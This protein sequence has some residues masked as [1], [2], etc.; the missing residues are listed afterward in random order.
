M[1]RFPFYSILLLPVLSSCFCF[2]KVTGRSSVRDL[3]T[4][5]SFSLCHHCPGK[6]KSS[7]I[8]PYYGFPETDRSAFIKNEQSISETEPIKESQFVGQF[9]ISANHWVAPGRFFPFRILGLGLDY[10]YNKFNLELTDRTYDQIN[11]RI[12]A[13]IRLMTFVSKRWIG[14][15]TIKGGL[16]QQSSD[17]N[18]I[19]M[20]PIPTTNKVSMFDY[21]IGYGL[22]FYPD[23]PVGI[24]LEGGFG[25]GAYARAGIV[26][27][28]F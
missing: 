8:N 9:G 21:R 14:Y 11:H 13:D 3:E 16:L 10:N 25:G 12:M 19:S 2:H 22:Q 17:T 23:I 4:A 20:D 26:F 15:A 7:T 24:T 28:P 5:K 1:K 27:W 6:G 18:S